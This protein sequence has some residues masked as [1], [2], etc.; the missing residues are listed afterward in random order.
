MNQPRAFQNSY[1]FYKELYLNLRGIPKRDRFTWGERCE[2]MALEL[3]RLLTKATYT[4]RSQQRTLLSQA[5]ETV[6]LLKIYLRLGC[7]LH[8]LDTQ[9]YIARES[10]LHNI[11]NLIGGWLKTV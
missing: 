8:I 4:P 2:T 7:D 1:D 5:G 11:G 10:E 3:V 6:D 9:K